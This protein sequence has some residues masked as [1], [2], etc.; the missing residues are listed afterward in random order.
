MMFMALFPFVLLAT[1]SQAEEIEKYSARVQVEVHAGEQTST[2]ASYLKREL[3]SLGDV[4]IVENNSEWLIR[5][6]AE[7]LLYENGVKAGAIAVSTVIVRPF[8]NR[9]FSRF[10]QPKYK[11]VGSYFTSGLVSF[12]GQKLML[13]PTSNL[14]EVCRN[15]IA[16]FDSGILD[17]ERKNFRTLQESLKK[18]K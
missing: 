10:L 18:T 5:I 9:S 17:G 12:Y 14:Q 13:G 8:D 16:D 2:I 11:D 4:E 3:R 1:Q 7:E 6:R 15:I